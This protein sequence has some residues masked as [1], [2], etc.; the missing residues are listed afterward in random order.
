MENF[1]TTATFSL[2]TLLSLAACVLMVVRM[3]RPGRAGALRKTQFRLVGLCAV[4]ASALFIYRL[5]AVH[6][7]WQPLQAHE[8]GLLIIAVLLSCAVLFLQAER[9]MPEF[10][11]FALPLLTLLLAWGI[12]ASWWTYQPFHVASLWHVFHLAS[13]YAG[14][15]CFC[16]AAIAG[17]MYL[18][19]QYW[20]R[21][22]H[23]RPPLG[24]FASLETLERMIVSSSAVGFTLLTAGLVTGLILHAENAGALG[25]GWWYSPKIVLG[26]AAWLVWALVM[27]VRYATHFRGARAAWLSIVG[28]LLLLAAFAAATA[29][30]NHPV[31]EPAP[32][33]LPDT[34]EEATR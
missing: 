32:D 6:G 4:L 30:R 22:R 11:G 21:N 29:L 1:L 19:A 10:S 3:V 9:R 8:D 17:V 33:R 26:C 7:T 14:A 27:N 20:L 18:Y 2:M 25:P 34:F 15:L 12:C 28:L 16:V 5:L 31:P 24:P 13:V 23:G